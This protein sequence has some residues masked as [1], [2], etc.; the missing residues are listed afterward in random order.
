LAIQER[1]DRVFDPA[2]VVF[3]LLRMYRPARPAVV[4]APVSRRRRHA[5]RPRRSP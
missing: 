1:D 4:T 2:V 5:P 3:C